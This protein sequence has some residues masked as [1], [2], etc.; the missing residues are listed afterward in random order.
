MQGWAISTT[1]TPLTASGALVTGPASPPLGLGSAALAVGANGS[2]GA[3]L[4][5]AGFHGTLLSDLDKLEYSTYSVDFGV[6]ALARAVYLVLQV[7]LNGD[8][9]PDDSL[10]FEPEYQNGYTGNVPTQANLVLAVWQEWDALLGGWQSFNGFASATPAAGVKTIAHYAGVFP[11]ARIV[12][13]ISMDGVR[14]VAGFGA[15]AWDHFVGN[16][17]TFEISTIS[18]DVTTYDFEGVGFDLRAGTALG[19]TEPFSV[20]LDVTSGRSE[21]VS[22]G[23]RLTYDASKVS[24]QSVTKGSGIPASWTFTYENTSVPGEVDLVLTD[25]SPT[26]SAIS[27]PFT[28]LEAIQLTF[29][30]LGINC[31]PATFGFNAAPPAGSAAENAFPV[32]QYIH[33]LDPASSSVLY[34]A[35]GTSGVIGPE[36]DDHGFIRGNVNNRAAHALDIGD[37]TDM[38]NTFFGSL[39]ANPC[40]AAYDTNNDGETDITD[41]I[42]LV[43]GIFNSSVIAI[44]P[45]N[46]TTPGLGIPGVVAPDGGAIPSVLGCAEGETCP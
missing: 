25:T 27:G 24:L 38:A 39:P 33:Y 46:F 45:P 42:T 26:A 17:D 41:L 23:A 21:V 18:T 10:I 19:P 9:N 14:I 11:N 36:V 5:H 34:D 40:Q 15:G 20:Y 43:Q 8:G 1:G 37:V 13:S 6:G 3:E 2:G 16:A 44:R 4:R 32:N 29:Q 31:S 30:R 12:N 22:I 35:P 28:D 7:D